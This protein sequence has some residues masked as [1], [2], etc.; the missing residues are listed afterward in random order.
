MLGLR[1]SC[2]LLIT[3]INHSPTS[4]YYSLLRIYESHTKSKH[5]NLNN[6]TYIMING[7]FSTVIMLPNAIHIKYIK[8]TH[9]IL[10]KLEN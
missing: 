2:T 3:Y 9:C 1:S 6:H 8:S 4:S 7:K 5:D 10:P